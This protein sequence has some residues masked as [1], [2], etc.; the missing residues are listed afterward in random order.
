MK[1]DAELH[2]EE[3]RK[4]KEL[5]EA[6]NSADALIYT[7]EKTLKEAKNRPEIASLVKEVEEKLEEL[8][9]VKESE[10]TEDIKNKTNELSQLIQR[11]GAELYKSS[12]GG[13]TAGEEKK[14]S[15]DKK[16][17]DKEDNAE[18]GEYKEK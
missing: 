11:V 8:K 5:A 10:N 2:A 6:R 3:D 18:E 17:G 14:E 7:C 1:R 13:Q 16:E 4:K 15:E 12:S 9:K